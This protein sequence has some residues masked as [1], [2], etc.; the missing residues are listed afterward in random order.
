M[1][2]AL[3]R[4]QYRSRPQVSVQTWRGNARRQQSQRGHDLSESHPDVLTAG[5]FRASK[6][7]NK[8]EL[9]SSRSRL[10]EGVGSARGSVTGRQT[11]PKTNTPSQPSYTHTSLLTLQQPRR[12]SSGSA[13]LTHA[14]SLHGTRWRNDSCAAAGTD[15]TAVEPAYPHP[16]IPW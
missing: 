10:N 7:N 6:D 11:S 16:Y 4:K 15:S 5:W 3:V 14:Q 8:T 1:N 2:N 12:R 9:E 13:H